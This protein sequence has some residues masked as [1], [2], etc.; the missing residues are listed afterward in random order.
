MKCTYNL[1]RKR[2]A[3]MKFF[4]EEEIEVPRPITIDLICELFLIYMSAFLMY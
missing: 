4:G 3:E 2:E 1:E